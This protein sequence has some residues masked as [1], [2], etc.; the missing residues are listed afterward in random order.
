MLR[1]TGDAAGWILKEGG[2]DCGCARR[3]VQSATG[4][5]PGSWRDAEQDS[6]R[7]LK[8]TSLV[9]FL[10][11]DKKVTY[12]LSKYLEMTDPSGSVIFCRAPLDKVGLMS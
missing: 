7:L 1:A 5:K 12:V 6:Q 2:L 9:T 3:H 8:L 4:H 11:S 10:F